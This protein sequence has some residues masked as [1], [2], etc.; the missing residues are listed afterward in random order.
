M[1]ETTPPGG[2]GTKSP[3][4]RTISQEV[5]ML[6][7]ALP[8]H[9]TNGERKNQRNPPTQVHGVIRKGG[10]VRPGAAGHFKPSSAKFIAGCDKGEMMVR[11]AP[12]H[13]QTRLPQDH[14]AA[15]ILAFFAVDSSPTEGP[16]KGS[17]TTPCPRYAPEP[18]SRRLPQLEVLA[19]AVSR[20]PV[21]TEADL[22]R[23]VN[24]ITHAERIPENWKS[25]ML[26]ILRDKVPNLW[27]K[28]YPAP[29]IPTPKRVREPSRYELQMMGI[30]DLPPATPGNPTHVE[31]VKKSS[32]SLSL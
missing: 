1:S 3:K 29:R 15:R 10:Y 28:R 5:A 23:A 22:I 2:T 8:R 11:V 25:V 32:E 31:D 27:N 7:M 21:S 13:R 24:R 12:A 16:Y 30:K 4:P 26:E 18:P 6:N 14:D 9:M 17:K 19:E 20:W